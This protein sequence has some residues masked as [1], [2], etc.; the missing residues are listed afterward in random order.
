MIQVN[1]NTIL[2]MKFKSHKQSRLFKPMTI[3][4]SKVQFSLAT[5]KAQ[6]IL[7]ISKTQFTLALLKAQTIYFGLLSKAQGY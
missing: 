2:S 3:Y 6:F 7:A 5:S 1:G 4:L